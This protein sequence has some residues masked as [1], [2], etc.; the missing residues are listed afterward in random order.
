MKFYCRDC[1]NQG[2]EIP[3]SGCGEI[4]HVLFDGYSF[5]ERMLEGVMFRAFIKDG[6][7]LNDVSAQ[8]S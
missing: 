5:G 2:N 8:P 4:P 1:D 6:R 3:D 7:Q